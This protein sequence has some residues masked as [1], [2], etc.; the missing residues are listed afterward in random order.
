MSSRSAAAIPLTSMSAASVHEAGR[1][2]AVW[3]PPPLV[4]WNV[5]PWAIVA[6]RG[7]K[8]LNA[9]LWPA[10]TAAA[11]SAAIVKSGVTGVAAA[12]PP[13][14]SNSM[15]TS[16]QTGMSGDARL[17]I[18]SS[19]PAW[20][21]EPPRGRAHRDAGPPS[22]GRTV[23]PRSAPQRHR[24]MRHRGSVV[25][26]KVEDAG[27]TR[28]TVASCSPTRWQDRVARTCQWPQLNPS[29]ALSMPMGVAAIG[30]IATTI[31]G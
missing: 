22:P 8:S 4:N 23:P 31:L 11:R 5:P 15:P 17:I 3:K 30:R 9:Q 10:G 20:A 6:L 14:V 27:G 28:S 12:A 7:K 18:G 13:V 24:R 29:G 26:G 16:A 21:P 2:V 19:S 1:S 25:E